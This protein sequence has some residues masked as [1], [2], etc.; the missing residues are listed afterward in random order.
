MNHL[1]SKHPWGFLEPGKVDKRPMF[2]PARHAGMRTAASQEYS[3][4]TKTLPPGLN[5]SGGQAK[6]AF[7]YS[8]MR[9]DM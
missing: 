3:D 7:K 4:G 6:Q 9:P 1:L 2:C 5:Q 8:G